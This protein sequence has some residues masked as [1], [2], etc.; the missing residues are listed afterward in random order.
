MLTRYLRLLA[1]AVFAIALPVAAHHVDDGDAR[2]GGKPIAPARRKRCSGTV[3]ELIVVDRVND[4][5]HRYPIL[6][7]A[8][9]S[10][11]ALRGDAIQTLDGGRK[12]DRLRQPDRHVVHR[13]AR[14]RAGRRPEEFARRPRARRSQAASWSRT[15]TISKPERASSSTR[16]STTGQH[17]TDIDLPFLPGPLATGMRVVVQGN[18]AADGVEHRSPAPSTIQSALRTLNA[19]PATTN[20]LVLPIKFP[21]SGS[22]PRRPWVYNADPFTPASLNTAV[23]GSASHQERQGILQGGLLRPAATRPASPPTTEAAAS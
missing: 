17:A 13:R 21:T 4:E 19:L 16:C 6:R 15:P 2:R 10:R 20:Y 9:G 23:F 12:G 1:F 8:D 5:T 14:R 11:V 18:V 22:E 3:D 7:Q